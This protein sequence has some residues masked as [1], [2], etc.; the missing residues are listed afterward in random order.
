MVVLTKS[1]LR[2]PLQSDLTEAED[3]A[4]VIRASQQLG[5]QDIRKSVIQMASK[6][7][8]VERILLSR[9]HDIKEWAISA[10]EELCASGKPVSPEDGEK[11]GATTVIRIWEI[12]QQLNA[13][14][15]CRAGCRKEFLES[16]VKEK[17]GLE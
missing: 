1:F 10:Y 17:F 11:L 4:R 3:F 2:N 7:N 13:Q 6:L 14:E 8:P 9:N 16:T 5:F 12:Q 15:F